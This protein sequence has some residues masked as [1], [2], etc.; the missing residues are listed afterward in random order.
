M[1][2]LCKLMPPRDE[3]V[4]LWKGKKMKKLKY[5]IFVVATL[6]VVAPQAVLAEPIE[7]LNP[8][9]E[10]VGGQNINVKTMGTS[11][12]HWTGADGV[13]ATGTSGVEGEP[14]SDWVCAA[15]YTWQTTEGSVY[16]LT[17]YTIG[18]GDEY[19]LTFDAYYLWA[20]S[21]A[22]WECTY[23]GRLYYD[24]GGARTVI[25]YIEEI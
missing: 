1:E 15:V 13:E 22:T 7:V 17:D 21:P 18:A 2:V 6:F 25:D 3:L 23:Q 14:E 8:S 5:V 10:Y 9:F 11:P 16:Q 19:T 24:D 4:I 12:D 20:S